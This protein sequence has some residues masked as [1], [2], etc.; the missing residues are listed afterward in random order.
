M[1]SL[2]AL[3]VSSLQVVLLT[4]AGH[5][6]DGMNQNAMHLIVDKEKTV[7]RLER[8]WV[9]MI[10]EIFPH[11]AEI[12]ETEKAAAAEKSGPRKARILD[13]LPD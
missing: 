2:V 6:V 5:A 13:S 1:Y 11:G 3:V 12:L 7:A 9:E 10:D 4:L 8:F